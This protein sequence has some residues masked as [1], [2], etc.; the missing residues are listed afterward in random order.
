VVEFGEFR[1]L[2][3][4]IQWQAALWENGQDTVKIPGKEG[5]P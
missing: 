5:R 3:R 4:W 1:F 2:V